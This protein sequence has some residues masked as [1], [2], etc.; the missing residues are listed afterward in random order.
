MRFYFNLGVWLLVL[1]NLPFCVGYITNPEH[2]EWLCE[3][4]DYTNGPYWTYQSASY[5]VE[6]ACSDITDT[7]NPCQDNW[8]S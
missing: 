7:T 8:V 3:L 1:I 2:V 4:Y 6:W 5:G